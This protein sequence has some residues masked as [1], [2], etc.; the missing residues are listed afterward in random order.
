M[1][2]LTGYFQKKQGKQKQDETQTQH[3]NRNGHCPANVR[4][5]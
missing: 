1:E 2:L 4:K 3:I 5:D